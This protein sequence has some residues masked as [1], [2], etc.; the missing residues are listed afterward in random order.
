VESSRHKL[1]SGIVIIQS[2]MGE[3][4]VAERKYLVRGT[5][6]S[7][8]YGNKRIRLRGLSVWNH[9]GLKVGTNT[10]HPEEV[11]RKHFDA[12]NDKNGATSVHV[13]QLLFNFSCVQNADTQTEFGTQL[14]LISVPVG[15]TL[16]GWSFIMYGFYVHLS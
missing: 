9:S 2:D 15:T 16:I 7:A 13:Q 12:T 5:M 6:N 8:V 3:N 11:S 4:D 14:S 1:N 10:V